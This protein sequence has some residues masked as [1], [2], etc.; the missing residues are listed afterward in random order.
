MGNCVRTKNSNHFS[1]SST[2]TKEPYLDSSRLP[3]SKLDNSHRNP[4]NQNQNISNKSNNSVNHEQISQTNSKQQLASSAKHPTKIVI[5]LY[6]YFANDEG[7]LTFR[8]GERLQ[9]VDDSDPD[10]WLAKHLTN[11]QKGFIPMNYVVSEVIEMEEY[12]LHFI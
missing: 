3:G 7:D 5:A 8:K 4:I 2:S 1:S 10:W 12:V 11:N 9:I 6:N